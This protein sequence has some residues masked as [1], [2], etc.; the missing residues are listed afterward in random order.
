M[1][2]I[3]TPPGPATP[4][5]AP[6][7]GVAAAQKAATRGPLAEIRVLDLTNVLA[8]PYCTYQLAL[9]GADVVK[10][11]A[12]GRGDLAR[13][14]GADG[15]LAG[16]G[17]GASFLAQNAGKRSTTLDLKDPAGRAAFLALVDD[18]DV[19]VDNFRPGVMARLGLDTATLTV[20]NPALVCCSISGFGQDGPLAERRA[21]DQ[22]VQ[23]LSGMMSVTGS[24]DTAP[25]R[26]GFPACDTATGLAAAFAVCAALTGRATT[27]HGA[28][29]DVSMLDVAVSGLGWVLSDYL[30]AGQVPIARGNDNATA[31]PSG[32][33]QTADGM[34]NI[35]ANQQSEFELL[36]ATIGA[37][38]LTADPRFASVELRRRHRSA[39][40]AELERVLASRSAA[41]WDHLL[42]D[43][44]LPV[45]RVLTIPEVAASPQLA[46]RGFF[47]RVSV[48]GELGRTATVAGSVVRLDDGPPCPPGPAPGLG[49]HND[50]PW[51]DRRGVAP[52]PAR[53]ADPPGAPS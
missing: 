45:G 28:V 35:A 6:T 10:V 27:G 4:G 20:R 16:R 38:D 23:G 14:L 5:T 24:A 52:R 25:L 31:A 40:T 30:I 19:V 43:A 8:G 37:A 17:I 42:S 41:E 22:V 15:D 51:H 53:P 47:H 3:P 9:L 13:G 7:P 49:E 36:C 26:A 18:A 46:G 32:T 29:L 39:L 1:T 2:A 34:L 50:Q 44:G 21:Y 48:S 33:F 12:P 11:E